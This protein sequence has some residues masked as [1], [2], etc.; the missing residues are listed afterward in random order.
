M[1]SMEKGLKL[2]VLNLTFNICLK[3]WNIHLKITKMVIQALVLMKSTSYQKKFESS[4]IY[5][6]L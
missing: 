3:V 5:A 4:S 2:L 1:E 6:L